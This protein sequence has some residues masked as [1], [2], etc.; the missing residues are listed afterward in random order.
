MTRR[1]IYLELSLC[2]YALYQVFNMPEGSLGI[3]RQTCHSIKSFE[4]K[5]IHVHV[6]VLCW[7]VKS[8]SARHWP[9]VP[10]FFFLLFNQKTFAMFT[11]KIMAVAARSFLQLLTVLFLG[12]TRLDLGPSRRFIICW[13]SA[14]SSRIFI[15]NTTHA[16]SAAS[17][18][19]QKCLT[20]VAS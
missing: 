15:I 16:G 8:I 2:P 9:H 4:V 11:S 12:F 1:F 14:S 7:E 17:P 20:N 5:H 10:A 13:N 19:I 3:P 18:L 6:C